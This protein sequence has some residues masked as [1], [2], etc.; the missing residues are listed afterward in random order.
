MTLR[1]GVVGLGSAGAA[2]ARAAARAGLE[3]VGLE[4]GPLSLAGARWVNGVPRWVFA[5]AGLPDPAPPELRGA[6]GRYHLVAGW[7]PAR[8]EARSGLEVDMRH[9]VARLQ[10]D[11]VG[12]ELRGGVRVHAV[13]GRVAHTDAGPIEADVWVDAT[14]YAGLGLLGAPRLATADLCVAA[15]EVRSIAQAAGARAFARRWSAKDG[16]PVCFTSVAGGYSVVNVRLHGGEVGL[17]AGAVPRAGARSGAALLRAFVAAN[18]WIGERRFGG[19]RVI[20]LRRPWE[21]LVREGPGWA[22]LA[23]GDAAGLVYA[24]HGSGVAVQLLTARWLAEALSAGRP[25]DWN[26]RVQRDL[27]GRL[28]ASDLFRRFSHEV[29]DA[30]VLERLVGAGVIAPGMVE[31]T[32]EQRPVRPRPGP[33]LRAAAGML[34]DPG[35]ARRLVPVL[36]RMRA[37]E[38]WWARYPREPA[39]YG[40]WARGAERLTGRPAAG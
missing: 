38:A 4:R 40:R 20:P 9:L 21:R 39:D 3:V 29:V 15:Q 10:S 16:E 11:A 28:A 18:P 14:G 24:A 25:S 13:D 23:V 33:L 32:M 17:L 36:A 31:D 2:V 19:S 27:G 5:E 35:L 6:E 7:G 22:H 1:V 12:A 34:R 26:V 8:I 37:A 30:A